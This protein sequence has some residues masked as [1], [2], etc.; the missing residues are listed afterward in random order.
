MDRSRS[1][2]GSRWRSASSLRSG[3]RA[4]RRAR[5]PRR[6]RKEM[7]SLL[8]AQSQATAAQISQLA[9]SLSAQLGQVTQ[10]VQS[11]MASVGT[12]AS[13]RAKSRLRTVAGFDANA[14]HACTSSSVKCS[15]PGTSFP[16]RPNKSK[17]CWAAQ[18]RAAPWAKSR[19]IAFSPIRCPGPVTK[20]N[21]DFRRVRSSMPSCA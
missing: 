13:E 7:Q 12:M 18:K 11:G 9:Q 15:R 2:R 20:R 19:W 8:A 21:F 17:T 6:L 5:K 16:A 1:H 10:Q 3:D 14:G 4:G